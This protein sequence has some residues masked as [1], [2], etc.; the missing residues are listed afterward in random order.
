MLQEM[1]HQKLFPVDLLVF[2][3]GCIKVYLLETAQMLTGKKDSDNFF[4]T[5]FILLDWFLFLSL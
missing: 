5:P 2:L 1:R 3:N 4:Y